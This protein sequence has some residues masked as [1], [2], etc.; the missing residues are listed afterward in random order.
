MSW[1]AEQHHRILLGS[2]PRPGVRSALPPL[3][4]VLAQSWSH[5]SRGSCGRCT[6]WPRVEHGAAPAESQSPGPFSQSMGCTRACVLI[7]R[8]GGRATLVCCV[9]I[10][11]AKVCAEA[12]GSESRAGLTVPIFVRGCTM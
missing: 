3:V 4:Q 8:I 6:H 9:V 10:P 5:G 12:N 2:T 11:S 7:R 1:A